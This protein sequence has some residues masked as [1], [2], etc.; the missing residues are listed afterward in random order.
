MPRNPSSRPGVFE[1]PENAPGCY[2]GH[3]PPERQT[4]TCSFGTKSAAEGKNT[5]TDRDKRRLP[6]TKTNGKEKSSS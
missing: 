4:W 5:I 6:K 2:P 3:D 1:E